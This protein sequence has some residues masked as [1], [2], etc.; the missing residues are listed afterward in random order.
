MN[1]LRLGSFE[2]WDK[3]ASGGM[4]DIWRGG[5]VGQDV[6]VV[7]K[8]LRNAGGV[9]D[10][11][12]AL[13]R[14]EVRAV[15]RLDHPGIVTVFDIGEVPAVVAEASGGTLASQAPY[16]VME[17]LP[18]GSM[19]ALP[20]PVPWSTARELLL[21]VLDGLAHAHARGITHRD[22][23]PGNVL[24]AE[25]GAGSPIRLT[26][27]GI[28]FSYRDDHATETDGQLSGTPLYMA[29][30]QFVGAWRDFGPW[31]D[32]YA[33][34]CMAYEMASGRV[35][36]A[37]AELPA[38]AAAHT[39]DAPPPLACPADYPPGYGD[40]VRRLLEKD[41]ANRYRR[42][43]DAVMAL[44]SLPP[45]VGQAEAS[46]P[47]TWAVGQTVSGTASVEW[48][49]PAPPPRSF[50]LVGAGLGL[51]G[52]RTVPIVGRDEQC[53]QLWT[54]FRRV[55]DSGRPDLAVV[56][57]PAGAGKSRLAE[58]LTERAHETGLAH[59]FRGDHD[60]AG[61]GETALSYMLAAAWSCLSTD[62]TDLLDRVAAILSGAGV[63]APTEHRAVAEFL[64]PAALES[65]FS[66]GMFHE[67]PSRSARFRSL[68][69]ALRAVHGDRALVLWLDDVQWGLDALEFARYLLEH[70]DTEPIPVLV[71]VTARDDL[72]VEAPDASR[73]LQALGD[74]H[75]ATYIQVAPL[76][77]AE[78]RRLVGNLLHLEGELAEQVS[79]RSGGNPLY[80]TQ[81]VDDWIDR[82]VLEPGERGFVIAGAGMPDV[83][84]DVH[85]MWIQR[86]ERV[87]D[88][89]SG[90]TGRTAGSG[91]DRVQMQVL[92]ELAV[93]L[94][95]RIDVD[96]WLAICAAAGVPDPSAIVEPLLTSRL[97][98][99]DAE[100]WT[101][102]H[103]ML[104]DSI[105]RIARER[106]RWASHNRLCAD[107]LERGRPVPHW[108]DSERI[109]RHRFEAEEFDRAVS[110]LLRG[111]RERM[112]IEEYP[113]AI[114]LLSLRDRALDALQR[115]ENDVDRLE[116]WL[117]RARIHATRQE[118]QSAESLVERARSLTATRRGRAR[119]DGVRC[120]PVAGGVPVG[121][122]A[123]HARRRSAGRGVGG[124][125]SRAGTLRG[126]GADRPVGRES[127][128][129]GPRLS[130]PGADRSRPRPVPASAILRTP[131]RA[132]PGG[133]RCVCGVGRG[134]RGHGSSRRGRARARRE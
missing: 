118:F 61:G 54:S 117:A 47:M 73:L 95:R 64:A 51:F 109:G 87:L 39:R 86:L 65:G 70:A 100:R 11:F 63:D 3:I 78:S 38:L 37:H 133:G 29:P 134:L 67:F 68:A 62:A 99:L 102:S 132:E 71:V 15:A 94:G 56:E 91:A 119:V 10:D 121:T 92:L 12:R 7:I 93:A 40:W 42:A 69:A 58:W 45:A 53:D 32:L 33:L 101:F 81:L 75:G 22:L 115:P 122:G 24:L 27:F 104:C 59:G 25:P 50:K 108:G 125:P 4:G 6:P 127:P 77:D 123:G 116:G 13:F 85:A 49:A 120:E 103:H 111:A 36:F 5:H 16:L 48:R 55:V 28:A 114:A 105:E 19:E 2:I 89:A 17:Y 66:P 57:G 35:P 80:A 112:R 74:E 96:E 97:A 41:P 8:V 110:P 20:Y 98:Q 21:A 44:A 18:R 106:G 26:D 124:V 43:A 46:S 129:T 126:H 107:M 34:G 83:P 9:D 88:Q 14:R 131:G 90:A 23:K 113:A 130:R 60:P 52:L 128:G 79:R 76:S 72:L 30:E 82:G 1:T 31:T 84:D